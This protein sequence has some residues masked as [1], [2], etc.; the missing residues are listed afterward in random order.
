[1]N[2]YLGVDAGGTKTNALIVDERGH[3]VGNGSSGN[4]NHQIDYKQASDNIQ[5]AT[6]H[7]MQQAGL[8]LEDLT[9]SF[10]G[11]AGADRAT[12]FKILD[13]MIRSLGYTR[14]EI[15]CDTMIGLR[16]GTKK[17]YGIAVICGT[18]TN[19]AGR[20]QAGKFFQ[21]G[22]FDYMYGDFGGGGALNVEV[23]RSV[24]RAWDGREKAT[25]LTPILLN[26]LDYPSVEVMFNDYLDHGKHVPIGV[27]KLL[28]EAADQGDEVA[29]AIMHKQGEEL[30]KS[31]ASVIRRLSMEQESFDV[32]LA[33]SILTRGDD[34]LINDLIAQAVCQAA[35]QAKVSKLTVEPVVGAIWLAM[36]ASGTAVTEQIAA[37]ISNDMVIIK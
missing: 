31:A 17:P 2:Y 33:G 1:M 14:F 20:N 27:A 34:G 26:A 9:F 4:G 7:A 28:F 23:F 19:C 37:K 25:L 35:P 24:I 6:S 10:F 32:V 21:C 15:A 8:K 30:G 3:I 13:P 36:E 12:D 22:G 5:A 29:K 16:A 11:L 18:G